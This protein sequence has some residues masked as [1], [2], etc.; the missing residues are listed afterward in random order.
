MPVWQRYEIGP[1]LAKIALFQLKEDHHC[2]K[3]CSV[4]YSYVEPYGSVNVPNF[5]QSFLR[6]KA[7]NFAIRAVF[8]PDSPYR[9]SDKLLSRPTLT[10]LIR[11]T[12]A[13][14]VISDTQD[15]VNSP[16][17]RVF[18]LHV[19]MRNFKIFFSSHVIYYI[20]QASESHQVSL[21]E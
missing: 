4:A 1:P 10:V 14:F 3:V 8:E 13:E 5:D 12:P 15:R 17:S 9:P 18:N 7:M 6:S 16:G 21:S 2:E 19:Q 11:A 20:F